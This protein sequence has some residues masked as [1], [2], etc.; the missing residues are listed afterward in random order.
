MKKLYLVF[1]MPLLL[2]AAASCN[3]GDEE[4]FTSGVN[5]HVLIILDLSIS[6]KLDIAGNVP[7]DERTSRLSYAK[8]AV[9]TILNADTQDSA[10]NDADYRKLQIE[11]GYMRFAGCHA[12]NLDSC[13]EVRNGIG[14]SY[15]DIWDNVSRETISD[16]PPGFT[17]I[18]AA[19]QNAKIYFERYDYPGKRCAG[20][21][22]L[23]ITDG[24]DTLACNGM[25]GVDPQHAEHQR[26]QYKRR[27]ASVEA[28][29]ALAATGIRVFVVGFG[30]DLSVFQQRTLNWMAY[31]GGTD[32]PVIN[33]P[34][35]ID[36]ADPS[37]FYSSVSDPCAG[38][39]DT[40]GAMLFH[41]CRAAATGRVHSALPGKMIPA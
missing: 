14:S 34:G 28:V 26:D 40:G 16:T 27:R 33:V 12:D 35:T 18:A 9:R 22:V 11:F 41:P 31:Y 29:K 3:A 1:I 21:Y 23:L 32:N 7:M 8:E 20:K 10:I 2:F 17:S 5:P 4:L 36:K 6:M 15:R 38:G 13:I 24:N 39:N 25:K 30:G 37:A 19:L